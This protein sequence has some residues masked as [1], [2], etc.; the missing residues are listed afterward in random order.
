VAGD[1]STVP[2]DHRLGLHD[3]HDL[4]QPGSSE[5]GRQDREDRAVGVGEARLVDLSLQDQDLMSQR[6]DLSV[7]LVASRK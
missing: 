7:S 4:R 5:G 1:E 3:Q 6:E 2:T